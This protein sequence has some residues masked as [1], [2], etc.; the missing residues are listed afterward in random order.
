MIKFRRAFERISYNVGDEYQNF[1]HFDQ[2]SRKF[3]QNVQNDDLKFRDFDQ[4]SRYFDQN[5]RDLIKM[6]E[7]YGQ[8]KI[9]HDETETERG[10]AG[11]S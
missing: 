8:K 2:N 3:E 11:G 1:R 7:K 5:V 6:L 9:I 4:N 10:V